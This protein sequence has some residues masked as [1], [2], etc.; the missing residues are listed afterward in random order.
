MEPAGSIIM[1]ARQL[2]ISGMLS[3]VNEAGYPGWLEHSDTF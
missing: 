1:S 2:A 3:C